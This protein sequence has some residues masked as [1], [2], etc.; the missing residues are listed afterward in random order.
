MS[1]KRNR[2]AYHKQWRSEN[3]EKVKEYLRHW[4]VTHPDTIRIKDRRA[5]QRQ[6][7]RLNR[8]KRRKGCI[9]CGLHDIRLLQFD[10]VPE[11]GKKEFTLG[12]QGIKGRKKLKEELAKCDVVCSNH[13][14]IRTWERRVAKAG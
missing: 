14:A 3:P 1:T 7:A 11:R 10:H 5:R 13:H 2:T 4:A 6:A 9:D 8:F 12:S